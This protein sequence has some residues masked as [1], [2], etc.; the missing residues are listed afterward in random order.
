M[1]LTN[2]EK[3][4]QLTCPYTDNPYQGNNKRVVFVCSAGLLRSATAAAYFS[5]TRNWNTRAAGSEHYALIPLSANL[6]QWAQSIV[7]MKKDNYNWTR[8]QWKDNPSVLRILE[9][10]SVVL[11]INDIFS[12]NEEALKVELE[13]QI[14]GVAI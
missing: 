3:I 11:S 4:F 6:I 10:K 14:N 13:K 5:A 7:F 1:S 8:E 12:Y 2:T 9:E